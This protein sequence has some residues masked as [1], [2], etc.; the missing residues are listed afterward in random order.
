MWLKRPWL[1]HHRTSHLSSCGVT[2]RRH[3][4][5]VLLLVMDHTSVVYEDMR[6]VACFS[7]GDEPLPHSASLQQNSILVEPHETFCLL[8]SYW[9]PLW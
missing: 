1:F 7:E 6:V 8:D 3:F 5:K 2:N 9:L 4:E